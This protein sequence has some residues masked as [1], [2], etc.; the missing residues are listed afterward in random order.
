MQ[1]YFYWVQKQHSSIVKNMTSVLMEL[2]RARTRRLLLAPLV[3]VRAIGSGPITPG[4]CWRPQ[5]LLQA[6]GLR[7]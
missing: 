7:G 5:G 6:V 4:F 3:P 1:K 2:V